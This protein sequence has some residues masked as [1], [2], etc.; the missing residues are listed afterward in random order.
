MNR[1]VL[2]LIVGSLL[3]PLGCGANDDLTAQA[4]TLLEVALRRAIEPDREPRPYICVGVRRSADGPMEDYGTEA[5]EVVQVDPSVF[6]GHSECEKSTRGSFHKASAEPAMVL[7]IALKEADGVFTI[8]YH[9]HGLY[10]G[11]YEC[12]AVRE[13]G[14]WRVTVCRGLWIA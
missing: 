8:G 9:F 2:P 5:A 1:R 11:A 10:A 13:N 14:E 4:D 6:V 7:E 12:T 3:L